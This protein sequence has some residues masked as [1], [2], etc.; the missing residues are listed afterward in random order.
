MNILKGL[1]EEKKTTRND[2]EDDGDGGS[3]ENEES[4]LDRDNCKISIEYHY[5]VLTVIVNLMQSSFAC[6]MRLG[7]YKE[8]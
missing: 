2:D 4:L 8:A 6:Y 1:K 3:S 7:H 5:I